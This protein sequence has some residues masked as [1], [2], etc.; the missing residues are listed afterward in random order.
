[1][2]SSGM[3]TARL[4]TVSH[5]GGVCP[6]GG[7][8]PRGLSAWEC[9]YGPWGGYPNIKWGKHPPPPC[10][11]TDTC[12]NITFAN[13]EINMYTS[14]CIEIVRFPVSIFRWHTC[15][16]TVEEEIMGL[17]NY[18]SWMPNFLKYHIRIVK[19]LSMCY[20]QMLWKV[21][22]LYACGS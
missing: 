16:V 11:Q 18:L 15:L 20:C 4:L 19:F 10:G 21:C 12:E 5:P 1:M 6:G 2:H 3:R 9:A 22:I 13:N 8:L 7:C 14:Y 17:Q